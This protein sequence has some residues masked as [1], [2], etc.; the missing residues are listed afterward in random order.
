MSVRG[1]TSFTRC[2]VAALVLL[3]A[4]GLASAARATPFFKASVTSLVGGVDNSLVIG[5]QGDLHLVFYDPNTPGLFY[6]HRV[7][8]QWSFEIVD[9]AADVGAYCKIVLDASGNP[10]VAYYDKTNGNLK[11][12]HRTGS[13]AW[14]TEI[15]DAT[16]DV[17]KY[18]GFVFSP[19]GEFGIAFYDVTNAN[20]RFA[21]GNPGGWN[22]VNVET[23]GD[24]GSHASLAVDPE[25]AYHVSYDDVTN[26]RLRYGRRDLLGTWTLETADAPAGATVGQFTSIA[27]NPLTGQPAIAYY[28]VFNGDLKLATRPTA[29]W[30]T[31]LVNSTGQVGR[32]ASLKFDAQ[33]NPCIAYQDSTNSDL[34]YSVKSTGSWSTEIAD[35]ASGSSGES[36]GQ[37]ASLAMDAYGQ[38]VISHYDP[39]QQ[40]IRTADARV[41]LTSPVGGEVWNAGQL[42]TVTWEGYGTV[43]VALSTDGGE[44]FTT[45]LTGVSGGR[46]DVLASLEP[47]PS[48]R[49][50]ITR[51]SSLSV[52]T[53]PDVFTIGPDLK[54]PW[55]HAAPLPGDD[56]VLSRVSLQLDAHQIPALA[57]KDV[58]TNSVS[59]AYRRG[60]D[61]KVERVENTNAGTNVHL[62]FDPQNA[63]HLIYTIVGGVLHHA[64][65]TAPSTWSIETVDAG[66][67]AGGTPGIA[68]DPAGNISV[69]YQA[70]AASDLKYAKKSAGVWTV[71]TVDATG[72][73]GPA[74]AIA[75]DERGNPHIAYTN[76]TATKTVHYATKLPLT[77]WLLETVA[78]SS[79]L[80]TNTIGIAIEPD[81]TP[82]IGYA[83]Q[84]VN[85]IA[86]D[87]DQAMFA[88][89]ADGT[90][91]TEIAGRLSSGQSSNSF[92]PSVAVGAN[93]T[94]YMAF[95][96]GNP[97]YLALVTRKAGGWQRE[98][99]DEEENTGWASSIAIDDQG[100]PRIGHY[101]YDIIHYPPAHGRLRYT[102]FAVEVGNPNPGVTWPVGARRTITWDGPGAADVSLSTDGGR[103]YTLLQSQ[104]ANRA[105]SLTVPNVASDFC[106]IRVERAIPYSVAESDS[107]FKISA[108]VSAG[109]F[110]VSPDPEGNTAQIAWRTDPG[111]EDLA[112]YKLLRSAPGESW[113]TIMPLARVQNFVDHAPRDGAHYKLIAV[114]N[115]GDELEIGE[116]ALAPIRHLA[117]W[118]LPYRGGALQIS[119]RVD[120]TGTP[121]VPV[122]LEVLDIAGRRVRAL[123]DAAFAP[124]LH[125][126]EWDGR[127]DGRGA[128]PNGVYF[129]RRSSPAGTETMK[130]VLMQ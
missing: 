92:S 66:V 34:L 85:V 107:F 71:E 56:V 52:S 116:Q 100:R 115:F 63:P 97:D 22:V 114:T 40:V 110:V 1:S 41:T 49:I 69:T 74:E 32:F 36:F 86:G 82:A 121:N 28:D 117:A 7:G 103:S 29:S 27:L 90:W 51:A 95:A 83:Q 67:A 4:L 126:L 127:G 70:T 129:L 31:E 54:V 57:F 84:V 43:D 10:A 20:L 55:W 108:Y 39:T 59:Y 88:H 72:L 33:G 77:G 125:H 37:Y 42:E 102:S 79:G 15:V 128:L 89:R 119:F 14:S 6:Q 17:G 45:M 93:G 68:I 130:M 3:T 91:T 23:A 73:A 99:F 44:T 98:E 9:M 18:I 5:S 81:Q 118:P 21:N 111:P 16:G 106:K 58:N 124:G 101:Q 62:A 123:S 35:G 48:A 50:R 76:S 87:E 25:G 30:T 2:L 38:P 109:V 113:R 122:Q 80:N 12:A 46:A 78:T 105:Y 104:V 8:G 13:N 120:D 53:S 96:N 112:G 64:W 47:S 94:A 75:L 60:T 24:V 19:I 26:K 65:K 11:F 61:W